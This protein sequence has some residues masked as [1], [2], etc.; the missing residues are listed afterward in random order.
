MIVNVWRIFVC[1]SSVVVAVVVDYMLLFVFFS[2]FFCIYCLTRIK[3]T[4]VCVSSCYISLQ[5]VRKVY[6]F[7]GEIRS[8]ELG[9]GSHAL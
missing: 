8:K 2:C 5:K 7:A 6:N 4:H 9:S 3:N 1:R